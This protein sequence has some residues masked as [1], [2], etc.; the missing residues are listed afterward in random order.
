MEFSAKSR[1]KRFGII[2]AMPKAS[3]NL[4]VPRN[5]AFVISLTRPRI[6]E[7]RVKKESER[8]EARSDVF[9]F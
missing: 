6:R 9:F 2:K 4:E 1:L 7:H 5:E 3:A 8:P